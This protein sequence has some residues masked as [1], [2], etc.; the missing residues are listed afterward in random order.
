MVASDAELYGTC[1][2]VCCAARVKGAP[3]TT[4]RAVACRH[5]G[6]YCVDHCRYIGWE[7]VLSRALVRYAASEARRHGGGAVFF[8]GQLALMWHGTG[9]KRGLTWLSQCCYL[10][11]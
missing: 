10:V 5:G 6:M 7:V 3:A 8:V 9:F 1:V 2:A 11:S 4:L